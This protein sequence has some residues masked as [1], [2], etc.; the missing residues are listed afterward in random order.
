MFFLVSRTLKCDVAVDAILFARSAESSWT[1]RRMYRRNETDFQRPCIIMIL[2]LMPAK[3][4]CMAKLVRIECVPTLSILKPSFSSPTVRH[5]ALSCL[6]MSSADI[7]YGPSLSSTKFTGVDSSVP[8][9]FKI[10]V[11]RVPQALTG[12]RVR[13]DLCWIMV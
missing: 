6:I 2:S 13:C 12:H 9:N 4:S 11:M 5:A 1:W 8:L 10:D 3:C 7:W